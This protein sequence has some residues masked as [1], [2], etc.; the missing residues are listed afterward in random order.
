MICTSQNG[1]LFA[2]KNKQIAWLKILVFF[3]RRLLPDLIVVVAA[4]VGGKSR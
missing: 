2:N 3:L 1:Y 4:I